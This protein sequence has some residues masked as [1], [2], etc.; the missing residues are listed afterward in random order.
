M[1]RHP[2][3]TARQQPRQLP[4]QLQQ[5]THILLAQSFVH[6]S[7]LTNALPL[8]P[9]RQVGKTTLALE[10]AAVRPAVYL[11]LESRM[12][13]AKIAEPELYLP[14]NADKLVILDEIQRA[15]YLFATLHSQI[16]AAASAYSLR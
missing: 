8:L 6:K 5:R 7:L 11:D 2:N 10:V 12:D 14:Q 9:Q 3:P 16:V 13:L 1:C 4:D 15:P